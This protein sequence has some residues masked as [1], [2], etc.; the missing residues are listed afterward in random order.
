MS[1]RP[2]G[3]LAV[4]GLELRPLAVEQL[5]AVFLDGT[6]QDLFGDVNGL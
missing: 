4:E 1:A 6:R 2:T 3:A 5:F